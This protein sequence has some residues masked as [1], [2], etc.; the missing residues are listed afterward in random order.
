MVEGEVVQELV[1]LG[2][3]LSYNLFNSIQNQVHFFFLSIEF[4]Y[5]AHIYGDVVHGVL[6]HDLLFFNWLFHKI[7]GE[8]ED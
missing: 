1:I 5:L 7:T 8:K 6:E 4:K 2:P 3:T